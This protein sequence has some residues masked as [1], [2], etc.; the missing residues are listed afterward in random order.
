MCVCVTVCLGSRSST[1]RD[2]SQSARQASLRKLGRRWALDARGLGE[3][4]VL[5]PVLGGKPTLEVPGRSNKSAQDLL[6]R[7]RRPTRGEN[8]EP[9]SGSEPSCS[10]KFPR[11]RTDAGVRKSCGSCSVGRTS[12]CRN[13]LKAPPAC[14]QAGQMR[15]LSRRC[16]RTCALLHHISNIPDATCSTHG[17]RPGQYWTLAEH[18][19][20]C[21]KSY[22][23][24]A[25]LPRQWGKMRGISSKRPIEIACA[26]LLEAAALCN[27]WGIGEA[28]ADRSSMS[29]TCKVSAGLE[30]YAGKI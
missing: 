2:R 20:I 25:A 7:P 12:C 1:T 9:S 22:H 3:L 15:R 8:N 29:A 13:G 27:L 24:T 16:G 4:V 10:V 30:G 21:V 26:R 17:K 19:A 6:N 14:R 23:H 28:Q 18:M 11:R 5:A